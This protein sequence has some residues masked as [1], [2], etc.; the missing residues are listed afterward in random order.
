M[1]RRGRFAPTPSGQLH[2]GNAFA[3][4][5]AW[6]QMRQADGEFVLRIEDIDKARARPEYAERIVEDLAW[7]GL[8]W[9]EGPKKGGPYMPYVQ[10]LREPLYEEA[11][12]RLEQ[13]NRL[14]PCFCSRSDLASIGSAP[15]GLASEG[16]AYP[17]FCRRLTA[18]ERAERALRK[19]PA[20]RF[21]MPTGAIEFQDG[22][23]G[24]QRFEGAV[25]GDFIVKRADS[26]FSYQ[27]AVTVDDAAMRI[28]DVLR[29]LDLL[30]STPRQL[31]LYEALGLQPP[32][33][34]HIP[35]LV[36]ENGQRL[37]KRDQSLSLSF[38]RSAKI[39]PE[40]LLGFLAAVAGW[41]ERAEPIAL[42]ELIPLFRPVHPEHGHLIVTEPLL[43]WLGSSTS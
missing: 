36:N 2:V 31:A 35:L 13:A 20:L 42:G 4:L 7:M 3:A 33:F 17:G 11:L 16:A 5:A 1:S 6:L 43:Q 14:Y 8:D 23:T 37:A 40:R 9:D 28:T 26:L 12:A 34:A 24:R 38:L 32:A 21:V 10:S 18:R 19:V 29:G 41:I 25:L 27:L 39:A 30:D 22:W 15:H